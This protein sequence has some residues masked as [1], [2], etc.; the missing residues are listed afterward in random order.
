MIS[1]VW[2]CL[3][4]EQNISLK[5]MVMRALSKPKAPL[6]KEQNMLLFFFFDK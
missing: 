1:E 4:W 6:S 5:V 2:N 3:L